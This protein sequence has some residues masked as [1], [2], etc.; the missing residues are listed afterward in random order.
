MFLLRSGIMAAEKRESESESESPSRRPLKRRRA[1]KIERKKKTRKAGTTRGSS[2]LQHLKG[3]KKD[4]THGGGCLFVCIRQK[5]TWRKLPPFLCFAH[6][7]YADT[8]LSVA[9]PSRSRTS[10]SCA[11]VASHSSST[12]EA[13]SISFCA[14]SFSLTSCL[15]A[16]LM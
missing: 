12:V 8:A 7:V 6:I 15:V 1:R 3:K 4:Y 10:S 13:S 9:L 2:V 14:A 16:L 5:E 11:V